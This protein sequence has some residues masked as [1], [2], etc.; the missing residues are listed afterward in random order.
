MLKFIITILVPFFGP[1]IAYSLWQK[2]IMRK[3]KL[4]KKLIAWCMILGVV[5]VAL[6]FFILAWHAS[7]NN[8]S[9]YQPSSLEDGKIQS[10]TFD[11]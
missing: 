6:C 10:G 4:E 2:I 5:L 3:P 9:S 7:S 11:Y 1:M 8:L